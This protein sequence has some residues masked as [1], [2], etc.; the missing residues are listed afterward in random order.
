MRELDR[1][2]IRNILYGCTILGTGGGGSLEEGFQMIDEAF[3]AG[4]HFRLAEFSELD[5]DALIGTPYA[6]GAISP[7]T[8][9]EIQKYARL[10][11]P[12]ESMYLLNLRQLESFLGK[13]ITAVLSTE[14]GG[15]NTATAFYVAAMT[16]RLIVDGDP[17][18]RSVPALQHSTY[19]LNDI[20]MCPMA[21][22]NEFGEGAVFTNVF[23]DERGE[24]LVRALAVVSR[25]TIAVM[26]HV[27][28]AAV[29]KNG[30]INGAISHAEKIGKAFLE[31]KEA[32]GDFVQA[33]AEA[34]GGRKMFAGTVV[35]SEFET[36]DGYTFGHTVI[37]GS[38]DCAGH[39]LKLWYQNENII[40]W[41]DGEPWATVPDLICLFNMDDKMPQLNPYAVVGEKAEV[42]ALPAPKEWTTERGLEVF[43]PRSFGYDIDYRPF[44]EQEIVADRKTALQT[45]A[46]KLIREIFAVKPGETVTITTDYDSNWNVTR[47]VADAVQASGAIPMIIQCPTPRSVGKAADPDLPVDALSAALS[48]TDVWI[49]FNHQWLLYSTP[50]ERAAAA[51]KKLRYMCLVDFNE[52]LL[53]RTVGHVETQ[54]LQIFMQ[55][56]A[57][58]TRSASQMRVTTPAGTDIS[59]EIDPVHYV[60]CDCGDASSPAVHMLTGQINV[61]PRFGS[62]QGTIVFDGCV[63]PPFARV[64]DAPI[65]LTIRDGVIQKIEGGGDAKVYEAYLR[66]FDDPGMLKMAH[67]SYGFNPGAKLTGNI[68]EDE[69]V[70]GATEWGIGYVSD[71][72]APPSGQ[73]AVSHSDG[74][75]LNSSVWLDGRCIMKEGVI[76]DPELKAL[77]PTRQ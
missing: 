28:T 70:W 64:P 56:V 52:D 15:G 77:D 31:A 19:Y 74:I 2:D 48:S 18:G 63:T 27:N 35:E 40:S 25:N 53:I 47:A 38:G 13:E 57:E 41:L 58:M 30:V 20:P 59:F 76:V 51:N 23:D 8:E 24:D 36:R 54:K 49:E 14:L 3:A 26:D 34:G 65:R 16:D 61:V 33:V 55:R 12:E 45:A 44:C 5:P 37:E 62:I 21:V 73:E 43:G 68:V 4:K 75:C 71:V 66:D 7:L 60:A 1:N 50:F 6:C 17:A 29:L 72:D 46:E 39:M 67:I 22:M 32:G 11:E 10:K 69:R 42:L 9:E